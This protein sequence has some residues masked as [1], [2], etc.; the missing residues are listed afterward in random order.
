M[1]SLLLPVRICLEFRPLFLFENTFDPNK[2]SIIVS[3]A[4]FRYAILSITTLNG[5]VQT[6]GLAWT[7]AERKRCGSN[8]ERDWERKQVNASQLHT[9][10]GIELV[11]LGRS[12]VLTEFSSR[13]C[14][15]LLI[16]R[17]NS[18]VSCNRP[19]TDNN[20]NGG[21]VTEDED[22]AC[23]HQGSLRISDR[24]IQSTHFGNSLI[25]DL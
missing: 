22:T 2:G 6:Q 14:T 11:A 3:S 19:H 20:N 10:T 17:E 21:Q 15:S 12:S 23:L 1:E 5:E 25:T 4:I 13:G 18:L 8:G 16:L 7:S 9:V 24:F